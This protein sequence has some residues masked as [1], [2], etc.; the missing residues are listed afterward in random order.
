MNYYGEEE[1]KISRDCP[2]VTIPY[3]SPVTIEAGCMARITQQLGGTYTV[4]VE[5]NLYRVEGH[6]ADALGLEVTEHETL[7]RPDGPITAEYVRN[8]AWDQ[9]AT[10]YDPEI[11][12]DIVALGLIYGF[13]VVE[14]GGEKF[15]IDARMTLTAP[16]CGMGT[17]IADEARMKL[18][19]IPG[20]DEATMDLVWDPPWGREMMS[21]VA[22]LQLGML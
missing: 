9:L 2:A 7:P 14:L 21:E 22:R 15:R 17:M 13:D 16:G 1:I 8:M 4:M 20:V 3:G 18:L 6:D 5:G 10:C 11:P 12:V 19:A